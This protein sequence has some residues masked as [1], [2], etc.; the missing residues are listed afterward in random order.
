MVDKQLLESSDNKSSCLGCFTQIRW[1]LESKCNWISSDF[2]ILKGISATV[3]LEL[4]I[5]LYFEYFLS[6]LPKSLRCSIVGTIQSSTISENR[7]PD[8]QTFV[9]SMLL[10][11]LSLLRTNHAKSP[12]ESI[13]P[14]NSKFKLLFV[15]LSTHS[16]QSVSLKTSKMWS[17]V[18][19]F[20]VRLVAD[21]SS[22][23]TRRVGSSDFPLRYWI[24]IVFFLCDNVPRIRIW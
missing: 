22:R 23:P 21:N 10:S 2:G 4:Q 7:T 9:K 11:S 20:F 5:W 16:I 6:I 1:S 8:F 12:V 3:T 14:Q 15:S 24:S 19:F 18:S 17:N 13:L